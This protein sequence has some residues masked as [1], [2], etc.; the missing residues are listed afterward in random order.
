MLPLPFPIQLNFALTSVRHV[1][2]VSVD[3]LM[4]I[5]VLQFIWFS[6]ISAT[7]LIMKKMAL[8]VGLKISDKL[9]QFIKP[10]TSNEFVFSD[11]ELYVVYSK[12]GCFIPQRGGSLEPSP[13]G[14]FV[15]VLSFALCYFWFFLVSLGTRATY[16]GVG[17]VWGV[18]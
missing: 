4:V 2:W 7:F 5:K 16:C 15:W 12:V 14:P 13:R 1:F 3:G 10:H 9:N 6:D 11:Y 17:G 8:S 18:F